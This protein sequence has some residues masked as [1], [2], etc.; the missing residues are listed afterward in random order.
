MLYP[1]GPPPVLSAAVSFWLAEMFGLLTDAH[2]SPI[3]VVW[4]HSLS[5]PA[6]VGRG[7]PGC[8]DGVRVCLPTV[9]LWG[10]VLSPHGSGRWSSEGELALVAASSCHALAG[11]SPGQ[12]RAGAAWVVAVHRSSPQPTT[13]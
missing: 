9:M 12:G 7:A 3:S 2:L 10:L 6:G 4:S 1:L 5:L 13:K 8:R 11:V